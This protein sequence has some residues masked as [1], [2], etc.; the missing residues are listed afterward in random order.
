MQPQ[1]DADSRSRWLAA[2]LDQHGAAL[3]LYASQWS[4]AA[5]DC[6]QEALVELAGQFSPPDN[7]VAWLYSVVKRRALNAARSEQRRSK[8]EQNAWQHR[9]TGAANDSDRRELLDAVATLPD[10]QREIVLLKV[11]GGLTFV[12]VAN[13]TAESSSTVH[14][15]YHDAINQLRKLW[16]VPCPKIAKTQ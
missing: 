3:A 1:T 5:D 13:V 12:E 10:E 8:Y 6:V 4:L 15:R 14:R 16:G 9:L 2:L 11:W 7:P